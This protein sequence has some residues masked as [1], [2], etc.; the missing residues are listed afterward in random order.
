MEYLF[1]VRRLQ[2][3][4]INNYRSAIAFY[5]KRICDYDV[6]MDDPVIKNLMRS[7]RRERPGPTK[8]TV[9]W[10]LKLVLEFFR[11]DRFSSWSSLSDKDL[12]LK[13]IF[14]LAL[15]TG[16]RRSELHAFTREGVKRVHGDQEGM[17][18]HPDS[19]FISKTH[20][21]TGGLGALRPV[22]IPSLVSSPDSVSGNDSLLC[23]VR[24]L[25]FFLARS[26]KYRA[27]TQKKLFISWVRGVQ[28]DIKPQTLSLYIKQAIVMAYDH[29]SVELLNSVNVKPHSVRHVA[30]SLSAL[31][32]FSL[33]EVLS[34]GC[35]VN[36]NVFISHYLQNF[37][38]DT[39][40]GIHSVGSFV[41]GGSVV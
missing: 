3:A 15:A 9:D 10:D 1:R 41:A 24:S 14:L 33:D 34:T 28:S 38:T 5:W 16:K 11:S 25:E 7:F 31:K 32:N 20:I 40:T 39:L 17:V 22:F 18:C 12:T 4:S 36:A 13:T 37:S 8:A 2:A 26:D 30:T 29:A 6:P 27:P 23:P 19:S 35:W 21:K